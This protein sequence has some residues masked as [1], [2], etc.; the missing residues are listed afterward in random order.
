LEV[1]DLTTGKSF[2]SPLAVAGPDNAG[3]LLEAAWQLEDLPM[4]GGAVKGNILLRNNAAERVRFDKLSI[5]ACAG[6]DV[7][8]ETGTVELTQGKDAEVAFSL[9]IST[10]TEPGRTVLRLASADGLVRGVP[11]Y[12]V[13]V[14]PPC[15]LIVDP[16]PDLR[17]PDVG[18]FHLSG[19]VRNR[20]TGALDLRIGTNLPESAFPA[21][22][23][24]LR[25]KAAPGVWMRF[26]VPVVLTRQTARKA[27]DRRLAV[28]VRLEDTGGKVLAEE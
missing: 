27:R 11:G 12:V 25:I 7:G 26:A 6:V 5:R 20:T 18:I 2:R 13:T 15:E 10:D 28:P 23:D 4:R 19:R 9:T 8:L 3:P 17:E 24:S 16:L 22:P 1:L 21:G 14:P